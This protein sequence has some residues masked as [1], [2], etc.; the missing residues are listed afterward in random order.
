MQSGNEQHDIAGWKPG[1]RDVILVDGGIKIF[2]GSGAPYC[3]YSHPEV[4]R[5]WIYKE[6]ILVHSKIIFYL[7][8]DGC[9]AAWFTLATSSTSELTGL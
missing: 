2:G 9:S 7:L 6:D 8:Q 4:D 5:L 1:W 3:G